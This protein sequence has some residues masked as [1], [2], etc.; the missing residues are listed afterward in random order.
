MLAGQRL[1]FLRML[2]IPGQTRR[3]C[4]G[5]DRRDFLRVG[6]L[7]LAGLTLA[8]LLRSEANAAAGNR[9]Q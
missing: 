1:S 2:T 5:I 3:L 7:G 9:R 4:D 6:G 8:D